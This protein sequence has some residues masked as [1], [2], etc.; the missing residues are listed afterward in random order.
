MALG[1]IMASH[2]TG[3]PIFDG[4]AGV[5]ISTLLGVMGV[6]LTRMNYRFLLGQSVDKEIT[7]D[8]EQILLKRKSIDRVKSVQSQWI[9]P[10]S[11]SFKAEVDFD[12]TYLAAMLMPIYQRE[13][14]E[15]RNTMDTELRVLLALYAEDVMRAVEREIR[16]VEAQIRLKHPGAEFIE[17]EPMSL[18]VDRLAIDDNLESDLKRVE[19]ESL[20]RYLSSFKRDAREL[21][22]QSSN[23][24]STP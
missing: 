6:A 2:V 17:L 9:G 14:L 12:G 11:F 15:I 18:D 24:K 22:R 10:D 3:N 4:V 21:E 19:I 7:D 13:F 8:I 1:G 5:G 23:D 20:D 16:H